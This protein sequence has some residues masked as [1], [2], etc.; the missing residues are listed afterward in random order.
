[1]TYHG[2]NLIPEG[3]ELGEMKVMEKI[4]VDDLDAVVC[5]AFTGD[6]ISGDGTVA[7]AITVNQHKQGTYDEYP[8]LAQSLATLEE[9]RTDRA[10]GV[11]AGS[12]VVNAYKVN[13]NE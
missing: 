11:D 5:V 13:Q 12:C 7:P 4:T 1:M 3:L 9:S 2:A 6:R 10:G 8:Q